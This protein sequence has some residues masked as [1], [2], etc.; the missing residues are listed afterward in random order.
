[1]VVVKYLTEREQ[2][3]WHLILFSLITS[4]LMKKDSVPR[5]SPHMPALVFL[6]EGRHP[7]SNF[8]NPVLDLKSEN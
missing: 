2:N 8:L 5:Y 4:A 3:L 7:V 1:M 6:S